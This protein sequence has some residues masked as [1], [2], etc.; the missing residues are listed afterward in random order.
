MDVINEEPN[1]YFA[2]DAVA[3]I[4]QDYLAIEPDWLDVILP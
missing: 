3:G 2:Y 4:L 1:P